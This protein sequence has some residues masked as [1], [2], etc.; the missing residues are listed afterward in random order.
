MSK[1]KLVLV[2]FACFISPKKFNIISLHI[3]SFSYSSASIYFHPVCFVVTL[4]SL[5]LSFNRVAP[6]QVT[7]NEPRRP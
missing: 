6:N 1:T 7:A 3:D 5:L 2:P 4:Y